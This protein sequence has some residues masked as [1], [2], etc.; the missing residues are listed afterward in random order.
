[1]ENLII[2]VDDRLVHGQV[3]V[4]W[5][6]RLSLACI[7]VGNDELV[8]NK[9]K[10]NLIRLTVP[11]EIELHILDLKHTA[12]LLKNE[13]KPRTILLLEDLKSVRTIIEYGACIKT[14]II[15]GLHY[16]AGKKEFAP[17]LWL[18]EDDVNLC[19]ELKQMGVKINCQPLPT[20]EKLPIEHFLEC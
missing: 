13:I 1:M 18:S 16:G 6:M 19:M 7:I 3:L 10:K 2:R 12:E 5:V 15:G 17:Y 14:I 9:L 4:G 20:D 11:E 8:K